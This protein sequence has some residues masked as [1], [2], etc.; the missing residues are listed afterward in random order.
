MSDSTRGATR[1]PRPANATAVSRRPRAPGWRNADV[2][3]TAALVIAM[4][5]FVRLRVV[6]APA[7]PRRV[8]RDAVR[9]RRLVGRRP[10][11]AV[12]DSARHRRAAHRPR[13]SSALLVGF[14]VWLAPTIHDQSVEIRRRLPD[15][16]DRVESL[17]QR[18]PDG[19]LGMVLRG[20]H[21]GR[22][23]DATAGPT[24]APRAAEPTRSRIQAT[25]RQ[26]VG[27]GSRRRHA[28]SLS[29]PV[30]DDRSSSAVFSSSSS[31]RSTSPSIRSCTGAGSCT[32]VPDEH[33]RARRRRALGDRRGAAQMVRHAAHRDGHARRRHTVILCCS[34]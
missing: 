32:S 5:L 14:G 17:G 33:A 2:L 18:A 26:R 3:R 8:P 28:L 13:D 11:G 16:I 25:L 10:A 29:V 6:R 22:A 23:A 9:P 34:T 7:V 27:S 21:V 24:P 19:C 4:Y 31:S 12:A 20:A 15:A 1:R 30:V